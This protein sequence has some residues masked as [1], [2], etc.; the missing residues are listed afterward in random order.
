MRGTWCWAAALWL[1]LGAWTA[2]TADAGLGAEPF[3]RAQAHLGRAEFTQALAALEEAAKADPAQ[4]DYRRELA[5]VRQVI[6]LRQRIQSETDPA[7]RDR[8][9]AALRAYYYDRGLFAEALA[10]DR[11]RHGREDSPAS[12]EALAE[13]LLES[14]A[15]AEAGD[16]LAAM[17]ADR[18]S[19]LGRWMLALAGAKSGE[20]GEAERLAADLPAPPPDNAQMLYLAARVQALLGK[21]E[22]SLAALQ[23]AFRSTPPSR[24]ARLKD[25]AR[26]CPDF[27]PLA[28]EAS[29][30]AVFATESAVKESGCSRGPTCGGCPRASSCAT[31]GGK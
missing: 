21:G 23:L 19:P 10:L 26:A 28:G 15:D 11:D 29:F 13:T 20:R 30:A 1:G 7:R 14:G 6:D 4:A 3:A 22:P 24:L 18:L 31:G 25:Q 8:G 12:A 2:A 16:I 17:G 9:A 27:G 5:I